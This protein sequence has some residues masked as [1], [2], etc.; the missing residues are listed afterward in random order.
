MIKVSCQINT[1]FEIVKDSRLVR[2]NVV[3]NVVKSIV[4]LPKFRSIILPLP[5][6]SNSLRSFETSVIAYQ[7][8]GRNV[9]EGVTSSNTAVNTSDLVFD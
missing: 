4:S 6:G 1:L 3:C 5:S 2:Y 7:S 8:T 9:A